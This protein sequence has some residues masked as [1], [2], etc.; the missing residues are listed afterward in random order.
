MTKAARKGYDPAYTNAEAEAQLVKQIADSL[1]PNPDLADLT[2]EDLLLRVKVAAEETRRA[3]NEAG[4]AKKRRDVLLHEALLVRSI[5]PLT[6]SEA[7][8]LSVMGMRAA[9]LKTS[10]HV[11][12]D[13]RLKAA[14]ALREGREV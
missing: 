4:E 1:D 7:A 5:K 11:V 9:T 10:L 14:K 6:V 3:Q 13:A 8:G 12:G 2:D